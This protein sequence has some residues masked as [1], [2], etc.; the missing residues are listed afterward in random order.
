MA[1]CA[2]VSRRAVVLAQPSP[3]AEAALPPQQ[4]ILLSWIELRRLARA[5]RHPGVRQLRGATDTTNIACARPIAV[6]LLL[7]S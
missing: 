5:H 4:V 2:V 3:L 1:E 6:A 7:I